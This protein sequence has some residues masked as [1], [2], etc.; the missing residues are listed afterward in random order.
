MNRSGM[1]PSGCW[2]SRAR[3]VSCGRS[4]PAPGVPGPGP[5]APGARHRQKDPYVQGVAEDSQ[6][7]LKAAAFVREV[8]ACGGTSSDILDRIDE[9]LGGDPFA[10]SRVEVTLDAAFQLS[11]PAAVTNPSSSGSPS[12]G[13][14]GRTSSAIVLAAPS[15]QDLVASWAAGLIESAIALGF[16]M[17]PWLQMPKDKFLSLVLVRTVGLERRLNHSTT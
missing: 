13:A 2:S 9:E 7:A 10:E 12:A 16:G 14:G 3:R 6:D 4:G 1:S 17:L 5:G 11:M 15:V 8:A